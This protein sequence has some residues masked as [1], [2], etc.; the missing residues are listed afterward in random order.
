M[1]VRT[2][3][4]HYIGSELLRNSKTSI[5][6]P[7]ERKK[8][9]T[10]TFYHNRAETSPGIFRVPI[11]KIRVQKLKRGMLCFWNQLVR[12]VLLVNQIRG[13]VQADVIEMYFL[14]QNLRSQSNVTTIHRVES[15]SQASTT[16]YQVCMPLPYHI[17]YR[18]VQV[19]QRKFITR[20]KSTPL[21]RVRPWKFA[22]VFYEPLG[23]P[24][25]TLFLCTIFVGW[26][27]LGKSDLLL[28]P[29]YSAKTNKQSAP[30]RRSGLGTDTLRTRVQ[31]LNSRDILDFCAGNID[32]E[33]AK[34]SFLAY[35]SF[36]KMDKL[37]AMLW[38][39]ARIGFRV[40]GD[41]V[42]TQSIPLHVYLL[43]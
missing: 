27:Y 1:L 9:N 43:S 38:L 5:K 36:I 41:R 14:F 19:I 30:P 22:H 3:F 4:V 17:T 26:H 34:L 40:K 18:L 32:V 16:V 35:C 8:K 2:L 13:W 6:A 21:F 33:F 7:T 42:E 10:H 25:L 29:I 11:L 23:R 39:R 15:A 24:D 12:I 37:W 31:K 28:D 20:P